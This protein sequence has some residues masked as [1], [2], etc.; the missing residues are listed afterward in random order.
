[1]SSINLSHLSPQ[2]PLARIAQRIHENHNPDSVH[3]VAAKALKQDVVNMTLGASGGVL[4]FTALNLVQGGFS[5]VNQ[6]QMGSFILPAAT[7]ALTGLMVNEVTDNQV[8]KVALGFTSGALAGL[9]LSRLGLA[10]SSAVVTGAIAGG[11]GSLLSGFIPQ[12]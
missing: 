5:Q 12:E 2:T 4:G 11:S 8:L 9:A 10:S 1:M 7:G 6:L 3:Q